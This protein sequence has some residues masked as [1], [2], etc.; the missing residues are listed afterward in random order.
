M[1]AA[2]RA[3]S[4]APHIPVLLAPILK[5]CAPIRGRW[6][7]GTFGAGG[8]ARALLDAGADHVTAVDRDPQ[9]FEM[10]SEWAGVYGDRLTLVQG[11]FADLDDHAGAP[12]RSEERR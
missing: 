7:D 12:L 2:A 4:D 11:D 3:R 5:A 8:Y 1:A 9:V 6:L 10:A